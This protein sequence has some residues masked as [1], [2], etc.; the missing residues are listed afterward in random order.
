MDGYQGPIPDWPLDEPT[1]AEQAR[2]ERLW[3][4]AQAA[5]WVK[6]HIDLFVA[7]YVRLALAVEAE[8][9]NNVATA[10]TLTALTSMEDRLGLSPKALQL[11]SWKIVAEESGEQ[12]PVTALAARRLKA[13]DDSA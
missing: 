5:Q 8:T 10:Q 11:L 9:R 12:R 4:T 3:R 13:V 6:L 1:A 2:W 7:R